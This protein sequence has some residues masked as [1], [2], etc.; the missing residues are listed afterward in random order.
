MDSHKDSSAKKLQHTIKVSSFSLKE[1][2]DE[3]THCDYVYMGNMYYWD[4]YSRC[5]PNEAAI[6][7][8]CYDT[9]CFG[10]YLVKQYNDDPCRTKC[11]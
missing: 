9:P 1:K 6:S 10:T 7:F 11:F 5:H 8:W 2:M 4:V 3:R